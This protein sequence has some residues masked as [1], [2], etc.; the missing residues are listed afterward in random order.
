VTEWE[1]HDKL[2]SNFIRTNASPAIYY[3][4]AHHNV[5]TIK[6]L[7]DSK[8]ILEGENHPCHNL[9][10]HLV[11]VT[12]K[13]QARE[14]EILQ[15]NVSM[16]TTDSVIKSQVVVPPNKDIFELGNNEGKV[17]SRVCEVHPLPRD[18]EQPVV[19]MEISKGKPEGSDN[20]SND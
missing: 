1:E 7:Q 19:S 6:C 4:P 12:D 5:H 14:K 10:L 16:E 17:S 18:T 2:L 11:H 13:I 8:Q 9:L 3:M 15:E 20:L